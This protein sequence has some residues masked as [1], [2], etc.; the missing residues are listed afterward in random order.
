M[1]LLKL[2]GVRHLQEHQVNID[3][4]CL[5]ILLQSLEIIRLSFGP[6]TTNSYYF[7]GPDGG[8]SRSGASVSG[9]DIGGSTR[10]GRVGSAIGV[11]H[12]ESSGYDST[13]EEDEDP[14][15]FHRNRNP[16]FPA[17]SNHSK[18]VADQQ[19][20]PSRARSVGPQ[21]KFSHKQNNVSRCVF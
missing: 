12:H 1:Y 5:S 7:L 13:D 19:M 10:H 11:G 18:F 2:Q 15:S 14:S 21:P 9:G 16:N 4:D 3:P 17:K 8:G 6:N 20:H